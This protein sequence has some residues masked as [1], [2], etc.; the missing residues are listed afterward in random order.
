[1]RRSALA[2]TL[3]ALLASLISLTGSPALTATI[4]PAGIA[5]PGTDSGNLYENPETFT[6]GQQIQLY[7]NFAN[8]QALKN[9]TYYKETSPGSDDYASIGSDEAN[10]NGNAYFNYVVSAQQRV[11]ARTSDGLVTEIDTLSPKVVSPGT[12]SDTGNLT[13]TPAT[14]TQGA[15]VALNAY[16]END[17]AGKVVTFYKKVSGTWVSIG[18]DEANTYGNAYL[19]DYQVDA[20]QEVYAEAPGNEC[21]ET[22][23]I[24]PVIIKPENYTEGGTLTESPNKV[25]IGGTTKVTAN[26]PSGTFGVSLF[27]EQTGGVWV[28]VATATSNSSGDAVFDK[29]GG[30]TESARLFAGTTTGLRTELDKVLFV[31]TKAPSGGPTTL[32][33]NVVYATTDNGKTPTTKGVDYTG[34][35]VTVSGDTISDSLDLETIAVRGNSTA[36]KAKKPYKLKFED[37][38]KPFGMKSDKTW[39]LLANYGD[40]SLIRSKV[41]WDLGNALSG[42]QWTPK[43]TFTELFINGK[44]LGSYQLVESIK[45]DKNRVPIDDE[46]GQVIENDPHWKTDGVPGFIGAS[47]MN[48]AWKDPDEFKDLEPGDDGYPGLDPTGLT[49]PKIDAMKN[50]IKHFQTVLYGADKKKDWSTTTWTTWGQGGTN[51][52]STYLDP[53]SAV[54]YYL[55]REF[56][57][58]NDADFYRSNF[59]Y[60]GNVF[61]DTPGTTGFTKFF[62]GPIWD[63]DRSAG[64]KNPAGSTSISSPTGWWIRGN[65]S[66]NHDTN[67]IHWFTRISKDPRFLKALDERW[68]A[69]KGAFAA[70]FDDGS[71]TGTKAA[72]AAMGGGD[73]TLGLQVAANDRKIWSSSGSRYSPHSSSYSGEVSWLRK[74]YQD[75][76]AWMDGQLG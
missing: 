42:L 14:V 28:E 29:V 52:W 5:H 38:Q 59:F 63:F 4:H 8:D 23:T 15:K 46:T 25:F 6:A 30:F 50:R 60:T 41:A 57:K 39:I 64:A 75:R 45:I 49:T 40:W 66:Q 3:F 7:A 55:A 10:T 76:Y 36:D 16:F 17:M 31:P 74:W 27:R 2:V 20:A 48:Y 73:Y 24:T 53:A 19:Y 54:D 69:K 34:K 22:Q 11:F 71:A 32:G 12:C 37:K 21:T 51:D 1:M 68:A 67:K 65:G 44:Y 43:S 58:D 13:T 72:V 70:V 56:T 26:F 61:N 18:T 35:A 62:M 47:G 33:T 9:V